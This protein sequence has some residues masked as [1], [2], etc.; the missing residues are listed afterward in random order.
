MTT[1]AQAESSASLLRI[2]VILATLVVLLISLIA[3]LFSEPLVRIFTSKVFA[4]HHSILWVSV[5][6]LSLFNIGQLLSIK[7]LYFNQPNI[8]L[9]PKG[10]QA[11]S[12]LLLAYFLARHLGIIGVALSL[13]ASAIIYLVSVVIANN[14][15]DIGIK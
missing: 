15:I 3:Y 6:G 8:Y 12:F 7:G 10:L 11:G 9:W 13:F 4:A 5:L 2:T 1:M 14:R